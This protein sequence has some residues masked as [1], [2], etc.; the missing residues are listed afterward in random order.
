MP[1]CV[2]LLSGGLD[3][4]LA[5]RLMQEQDIAVEAVT[6]RTLFTCCQDQAGRAA[7]ILGVNLT[8]LVPE[9]DYL[10]V[11]RR[12]QFGY[13]RGANP[14]IDCRIYMF[15]KAKA[16]M[17]QIGA[18]FVVSGEIV[19]QRPKSQKRRDL[20]IISHHSQLDDYLLR[21]L[22]ARRLP[23]T[24]P[25]REGLV[26]RERLHA[27]SGRSRKG[28][29][30]LAQKFGFHQIPA[31]S[32]GCQLTEPRFSRKVF[33]LFR[34]Q[35]DND[36]WSFE[37]LKHGRHYRWST[38]TKIIVG[39]NESDNVAL[40]HMHQNGNKPS[41]KLLQ[42]TNFRGPVV[43]IAGVADEA[44]VQVG[45]GLMLRH[46]PPPEVRPA[47]VEVHDGESVTTRIAEPHPAA[48]ELANICQVR[49]ALLIARCCERKRS[50]SP[51]P[52]DARR[53]TSPIGRKPPPIGS[54][55]PGNASRGTHD[56][57]ACAH[58]GGR[59][60]AEGVASPNDR[61][62]RSGLALSSQDPWRPHFRT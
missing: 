59:T 17:A 14:C 15:Q 46:C 20:E 2:A 62:P 16:F 21:P 19:G 40:T 37:L 24:W 22:C 43:L 11:V 13:G 25:E 6:F 34:H 55:P 8:A 5:I 26:D 4:M 57:R 51:R 38:Q 29:I 49:I 58:A 41:A 30:R 44:A 45:C 54:G 42:P 33:D 1:Q 18:D 53:A 50:P 23:P 48:D 7:Q 35:S 36:R 56:S 10:Q 32:T 3:S 47:K 60:Y 31:P 9:E 61:P 27:F 39:R 12:P 52:P 28:L